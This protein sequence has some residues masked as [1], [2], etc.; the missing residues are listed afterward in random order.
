M[1]MVERES[2]R[3][4][5]GRKR[6]ELTP[7]ERTTA[8]FNQD[9]R[10]LALDLQDR[11][12]ALVGSDKRIQITKPVV[13]AK[14]ASA[15]ELEIGENYKRGKDG[16]TIDTLP[17]GVLWSYHIP[18]RKMKQA[19]VTAKDHGEQGTCVRLVR[20]SR[21][22]PDTQTFVPMPR[23]GDIASYFELEENEVA[24]LSF[25]DQSDVLYLERSA[26]KAK[27]QEEPMI[28]SSEANRFFQDLL[29]E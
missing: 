22:D 2:R 1:V 18:V 7:E 10:T 5:A 6:K 8:F 12:V 26:R 28:D 13:Y 19:L 15:G 21:Y 23:E 24:R 11:I 16:V 17:E 14:Q 3:K 20:A 25:K 4:E 9:V 29:R 27:E